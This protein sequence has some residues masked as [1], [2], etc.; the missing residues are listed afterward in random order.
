MQYPLPRK[1]PFLQYN[2]SALNN[3]QKKKI[4]HFINKSNS[5]F[6]KNFII[7]ILLLFIANETSIFLIYLDC[8]NTNSISEYNFLT[9]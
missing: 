1:E 3:P 7:I 5:N 6:N 4:Y 2:V 9:I 8:K